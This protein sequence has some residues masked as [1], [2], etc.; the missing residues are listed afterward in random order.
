MAGA[1]RELRDFGR[2]ATGALLFGAPFLWTMETWWLAWTL[3]AWRLIIA[4]A[5]AIATVVVLTSYVGFRAHEPHGPRGLLAWTSEAAE[6][7][8]QS[9]L[10]AYV[11]L[12][13]YG[14]IAWA[15]PWMV[16]VRVGLLQL[17]A[18][19]VGAALANRLLQDDGGTRRHSLAAR[20]AWLCLGAFLFTLPLAPT[21]EVPYLAAQ[22]G[23]ARL[24]MVLVASVFI[25]YLILFEL[26]FRGQPGRRHGRGVATNVA[27]AF[28]VVALALIVS[29]GLLAA[30][31]QFQGQPPPVALQL[32]LATALP[33]T[34]G[35][36]A[37]RVVL[38]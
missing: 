32:T 30:F 16:L 5:A 24:A 23:W 4:A 6:V 27:E 38:H 29:A 14:I 9:L 35:G 18:L 15:E 13:M 20:L 17:V 21:E 11:V 33:A 2:G 12:A 8:I 37:A 31:G 28:T 22:A 10:A 36:S 19:G 34:I 25:A 1:A 7:M 26:E 3:P